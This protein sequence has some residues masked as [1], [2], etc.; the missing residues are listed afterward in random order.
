MATVSRI[1]MDQKEAAI[2]PGHPIGDGVE[3]ACKFEPSM[4]IHEGCYGG[5]KMVKYSP[6]HH[7]IF[8]DN[9]HAGWE[10]PIGVC[11]T[12]GDLA[13]YCE[14]FKLKAPSSDGED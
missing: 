5:I 10:I 2:A 7:R 8:C 12:V 4:W 13:Q 14:R 9:C 11:K 6:T 3:G 1:T